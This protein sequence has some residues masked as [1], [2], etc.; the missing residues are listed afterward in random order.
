MWMILI[1]WLEM[2]ADL[3][4]EGGENKSKMTFVIRGRSFQITSNAGLKYIH[5]Q[6]PNN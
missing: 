1:T 2:I 3:P 5:G 6:I 4:K